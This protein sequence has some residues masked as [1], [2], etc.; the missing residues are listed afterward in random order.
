V[1]TA[2][3]SWAPE[4]EDAKDGEWNMGVRGGMDRRSFLAALSGAGVGGGLFPG[5]L[6]TRLEVDPEITVEVIE[7]AEKLAALSFSEEQRALMV[8]NLTTNRGA[9]R[10]LREAELPNHVPPAIQFDPVPPGRRPPTGSSSLRPSLPGSLPDPRNFGELAFASVVQLGALLRSGRITS[11][12]LARLCLDRLERLGPELE[13]V[14]TLTPELALE[15]A[16]RADR[17][18]AEGR[19]RGPLHGIPWG[20]KDLLAVRGHPTTWGAEP[21]RDQLLEMDATVVRRLEEAGAVLVAK[22]TLGAL[23]MGDVWFGGRTRNP[24]N[25]EEGSSGSSAGSAAAVAAGLVPFAIGSETLGS[26]V[27]PA[28]RCGATGFR[29]SFGRVSRHGAMA[30]SWSMD[31]LGPLARTAEDCALVTAAIQG[32]DDLDRTV[33]SLPFRWDGDRGVEGMRIGR[34][35]WATA[36]ESGWSERD[37][38]VLEELDRQGAEVVDVSLPD[39]LPLPALRIILSAEAAA[40]FDELTLSGKD[41]LLTRQDAGAW[42]NIFRSARM[43]PAVEYIQ[44]NRVRTLLVSA[45]DRMWEGV[46]AVVAP[47]YAGSLLLATNLTGHPCVVLPHGMDEDGTPTSISVVGNLWKDAEALQAAHAFQRATG[48]HLSRPPRYA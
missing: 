47:P 44:A 41:A 9:F 33:R 27:S 43:I 1:S 12:E 46:D 21:Y 23:A 20:A 31:K 48:H 39:E 29:P 36:E 42:P 26:I 38:A 35:Q 4:R 45:M 22:L 5:I 19:V 8:E 18:L 7:E 2:R 13:C 16:R 10:R 30:L 40:A 34:L 25:L 24:W 28:V 32:P 6:W 14:V 11:V 37:L 3:G 17:E 15:Q